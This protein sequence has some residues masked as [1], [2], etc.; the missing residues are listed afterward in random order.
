MLDYFQYFVYKTTEKK[1]HQNLFFFLHKPFQALPN[2]GLLL[3]FDL[4]RLER[5]VLY[6][7]EI[8]YRTD[9]SM[10]TRDG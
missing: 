6:Q 8:C 9:A 2:S 7:Q 10:I 1:T 3:V 5:A 4:V